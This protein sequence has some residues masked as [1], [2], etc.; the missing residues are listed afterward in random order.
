MWMQMR[1]DEQGWA[2]RNVSQIS[3][4]GT[5]AACAG[6]KPRTLRIFLLPMIH[7]PGLWMADFPIRKL[8]NNALE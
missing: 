2:E 7:Q 1:V 5:S 8:Q 4:R 6:A 3:N